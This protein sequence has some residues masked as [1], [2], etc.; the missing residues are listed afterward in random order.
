MQ[1]RLEQG[2]RQMKIQIELDGYRAVIAPVGLAFK[3]IHDE[4]I[5]AGRDPLDPNGSFY[6]LYSSD[7]SHPSLEGSYLAACVLW[8]TSTQELAKPIKFVPSGI[9][10]ERAE[11]LRQIADRVVAAEN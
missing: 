11:Y 7:G 3:E 9:D 8:A 5:L 6:A 1:E 10:S 4:E 2:Y